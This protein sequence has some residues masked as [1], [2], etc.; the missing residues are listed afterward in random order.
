M[1][2]SVLRVRSHRVH[3]RPGPECPERAALE[4]VL[5]TL[6]DVRNRALLAEVL[7]LLHDSE[8]RLEQARVEHPDQAKASPKPRIKR[9]KRIKRIRRVRRTEAVVLAPAPALVRVRIKWVP[10]A[11]RA[12]IVILILLTATPMSICRR[13]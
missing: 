12:L 7:F 10:V 13:S 1:S 6:A 11:M 2:A 4:R 8:E 5:D 9:I 3:G